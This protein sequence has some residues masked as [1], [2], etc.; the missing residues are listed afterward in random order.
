MSRH[1]N[2]ISR[3]VSSLTILL[4]FTLFDWNGHGYFIFY[5]PLII[6]ILKGELNNFDCTFYLFLLFGVSYSL[7]DCL[8]TR[9]LNYTYNILPIVNFPILYI[10]GKYIGN[11]NSVK[12]NVNTL[13]LFAISLALL[14]IISVYISFLKEGF[15]W[16]ARDIALFGYN[17]GTNNYKTIAATGLYSRIL[18]LTLFMPLLLIK[19]EG[20]GKWLLVITAILAF[21]CCLRLQS[22][23][24]IYITG[25][26][27]I[28]PLLLGSKNN[29]FTKFWGIIIIVFSIIFVLS[30]YSDQLAIIERFQKN[31]AFDNEGGEGRFTLAAKIFDN[32][33]SHPFGG[34]R[35]A[36]YAHNLWLDCAR[37]S[38]WIPM[39]L[40][41][42]IT[43]RC[44]MITTRIFKCHNFP[45]YY[46]LITVILT[47]CLLLYFFTEPIL[48]GA[49][50]LF[51]Y[52]CLYFGILT[53]SNS[54]II[55]AHESI[56][57][58]QRLL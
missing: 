14:T 56:V 33:A 19:K 34:L 53:G 44:I 22:R 18:P 2:F 16:A 31:N 29:T 50:M 51:A 45:E 46:R 39:I 35:N 23:S 25:V 26:S 47:S 17:G 1:S 4:C 21:I 15:S 43:W 32:L 12:E 11:R 24:A 42:C 6:F 37:V 8:N 9:S 3:S 7:I 5:I 52:F 10:M 55:L 13:W 54:Q 28:I 41:I 48:E 20:Y 38:G 30:H 36:R 57:Y 40:L 27:L 49:S 58:R